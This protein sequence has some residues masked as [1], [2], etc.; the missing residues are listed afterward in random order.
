MLKPRS[1]KL[2]LGDL[3]GVW[4]SGDGGIEKIAFVGPIFRVAC[5]ESGVNERFCDE[6]SGGKFPPHLVSRCAS[7]LP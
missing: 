6:C 3:D 7:L 5:R 1:F 2:C 4:V